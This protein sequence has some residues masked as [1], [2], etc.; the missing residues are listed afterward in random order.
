MMGSVRGTICAGPELPNS[1]D[2]AGII[3]YQVFIFSFIAWL[4]LY[5]AILLE[6]S[7]L[8]EARAGINISY[9]FCH[10]LS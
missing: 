6:Y 3:I 5:S 9:I 7:L 4:I 2:L 1:T 8:G 10:T